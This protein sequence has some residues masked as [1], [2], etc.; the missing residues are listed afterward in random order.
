MEKEGFVTIIPR[1]EAAISHI[2]AQEVEDIFEIRETLESL[3][4]KKSVG[5]ISLEKVEELGDNFKKF[6][7]KPV[8]RENRIQYLTLDKKFHDLLNKNCCNQKLIEL[9]AN[10]QE[11]IHR[12]R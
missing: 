4:V 7:D 9:L 8:N 3:A 1:K 12:L 2:N 6:I 5:K 11:Q 10:I